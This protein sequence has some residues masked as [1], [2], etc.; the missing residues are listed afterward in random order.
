MRVIARIWSSLSRGGRTGCMCRCHLP[1]AGIGPVQVRRVRVLASQPARG[2]H[3]EVLPLRIARPRL[4][5][6]AGRARHGPAMSHDAH[7]FSPPPPAGTPMPSGAHRPDPSP[8]LGLPA[9]A[10]CHCRAIGSSGNGNA[11]PPRRAP[12]RRHATNEV[13]WDVTIKR[14]PTPEHPRP[15]KGGRDPSRLRLPRQGRSGRERGDAA[16]AGASPGSTARPGLPARAAPALPHGRA[17]RHR[18]ATNE[19]VRSV[20]I[21]RGPT[22][23]HPRPPK[24]GRDPSRLRLPRQ[25]R[26]GRERGDAAQPGAAP[27]STARPG[28]PARAGCH[29]RG[30]PSGAIGSS[31]VD[32]GS[33]D[34]G[35][36]LPP[37]RAPRRRRATNEVVRN[38]AINRGPTAEHPRPLK[39]GRGPLAP[40]STANP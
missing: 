36:A 6:R 37:G 19:V 27:G 20:T 25:G 11:L 40:L 4:A 8:R 31:P 23:E 9:R 17:P 30:R 12:L 1:S 38:V 14:G 2:G 7:P 32:G 29:C 16:Q 22:P 34:N 3:P 15:P 24:G 26:T 33:S 28:L 35:N 10:G 21:K 13:V 39:V 5:A 18:R